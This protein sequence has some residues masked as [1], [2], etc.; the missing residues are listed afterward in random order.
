MEPLT[1]IA[2]RKALDDYLNLYEAGD[3]LRPAGLPLP[4]DPVPRIQT[5]RW[6]TPLAEEM[7]PDELREV[8]NQLNEWKGA[9][10]RW[11]AWNRVLASRDEDTRWAIQWEF[12]EPIAY[13]CMFQPS[14]ARDRFTFVACNALH[15]VHLT[16]T[17]GHKD[18]LLGD[19]VTPAEHQFF[20]SRRTFLPTSR[21]SPLAGLKRSERH[22]SGAAEV[23]VNWQANLAVPTM[24]SAYRFGS[25]EMRPNQRQLLADGRPV[26]LG[27]R[28]FDVL[29]ALVERA[30]QLVTKD[31][32]LTQV[33]PNLVVEE[34]NLQVQVSTLRKVL[35]TGAIATVAGRGYRLTLDI[36]PATES[37][38]AHVAKRN[39][40]PQLL[41]SFIGHADDLD[42][43]AILLGE[44]RLLT[45]SGI[46]GCGK[47]RLAIEL[48]ERA[49]PSFP[50]GVC[51]VDLAPLLDAERVALTVAAMLEIR[52]ENDRPIVDTLCDRLASRQM[53]L[54]LDNCEHLVAACAALVQRVIGT[55]P[56]VRVLA[57]SREGLGVPG[58]RTVTVRSLSFPPAGSKLDPRAVETYEAVRLFVE[59]A[60]LSLPKFSL[61]G[62]TGD[63]VAEICRRLDGIPLAIELAA[64]RVKMLTVG[65]IRARLDDRFRLL[66]GGSKTAMARQQT[67]LATIQWSYD[68][69]AP[70]QQQLL[71]RLSIFV[72]GWTLAS[73][74]R[75]AG[76]QLDEYAMLDLLS[77]VADQSLIITHRVE[78]GTTRYS[79]L[80]TV[81]QYAQE[82]LREAGEDEAA[83]NR[84]L[85]FY[86][87]LAKEAE[88]ELV[89]PEQRA[90]FARIDQEREN[91]L[92]AHAWCDHA[93]N[94]AELGLQLVF[95]LRAYFVYR[96]LIALD[97]RVV[98]EALARPGADGRNLARCRALWAAGDASY[99]MGRYEEAK[100]H[101][102]MS[103]TLAKEIG[104]RGRE[105]EAHRLLG[106][107][108]RAQGTWVLAK[109]HMQ[110]SLSLSRQ[111][112]HKRQLSRA[113][114]GLAELHLA[115]AQLDKAGALYEEALA[116]DRERGDRALTGT[117][118]ANLAMTL[119]SLGLE[120]RA[121][122]LVREGL[123]I[124]EEIES[125]RVGVA[126]LVCATG[127][128]ASLSEW[129][130]AAWLHG[131]TETLWAQM[132]FHREPAEEAF[133][134]PFIAR[135]RGTLGDAAFTAAES[136]GRSL[137]YEEAIAQARCVLG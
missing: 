88:L 33:W 104:N 6:N 70:D 73:A 23:G 52:E 132:G 136:A 55:A 128:A 34:N 45:L 87:A 18:L 58:E 54:V 28:A 98:V 96:G 46:G 109:E 15:Q 5:V 97:H 110:E 47:T 68:H 107:V 129:K 75:V 53:L 99:F 9:L 40:L 57:A 65:E 12:V 119:I 76:G 50:D 60:Q 61:A 59:R 29:L 30:G 91:L 103:L 48:A 82:R 69:L 93:D 25:F 36:S 8:T 111:L 85:E 16:I 121:R 113:L 108:F 102:E 66:T 86:V 37:S 19:P 94:G 118:L 112:G 7:V 101:G 62:D 27:D 38:S 79:M 64:A 120:D 44:T 49:L 63:A 131:A 80:E 92:A 74:T 130:C 134:A 116:L 1:N 127:L 114:S 123:A 124:A 21:F 115:E 39:N 35:G 41:T 133:L 72:G 42:E 4:Y 89:G 11:D 105:A 137:S 125:K 95:A 117:D 78:G 14:S 106:Y 17:P 43:Y 71:Q 100:D 32:L 126:H 10:R 51:Y 20:P 81:R 77:R 122:G 67:L 90:W 3:S 135:T 24:A 83:R 26:V 56:G 31:E 2:R 13:Q 22:A 84:H